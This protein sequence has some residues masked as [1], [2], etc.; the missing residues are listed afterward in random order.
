MENAEEKKKKKKVKDDSGN[1]HVCTDEAQADK[2]TITAAH[3]RLRTRV[4]TNCF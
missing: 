2:G 4:D 1:W 3:K